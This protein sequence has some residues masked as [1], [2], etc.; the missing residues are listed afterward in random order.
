MMTDDCPD[1]LR[2]PTKANMFQVGRGR[3]GREE[4]AAAVG[5]RQ[6][7]RGRRGAHAR[8]SPPRSSLRPTA[9]CLL[10]N[11]ID[12]RVSAGSRWI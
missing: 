11:R 4:R 2:R 12:D 5:G 9:R 6:R 1:P 10:L 3:K 8:R 7:G